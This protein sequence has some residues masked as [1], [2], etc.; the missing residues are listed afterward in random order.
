MDE[1]KPRGRLKKSLYGL[2]VAFDFGLGSPM[3]LLGG[4]ATAAAGSG[5]LSDA[6]VVFPLFVFFLGANFIM[7][8]VLII[9]RHPWTWAAQ[10]ASAFGGAWL[11]LQLLVIL[12]S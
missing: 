5:I 6:R 7:A 3:V 9:K 11:I 12:F 4:L 8:A 2:V 10:A 1:E